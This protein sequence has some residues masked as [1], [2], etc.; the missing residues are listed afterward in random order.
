MFGLRLLV[1]LFC[2]FCG[3]LAL[4]GDGLPDLVLLVQQLAVLEQVLGPGLDGSAHLVLLVDLPRLRGRD[5]LYCYCCVIGCVYDGCCLCVLVVL[6]YA[7][8]LF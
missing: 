7:D 3:G 5:D 4:L 2:C 8:C 6:L 1:T